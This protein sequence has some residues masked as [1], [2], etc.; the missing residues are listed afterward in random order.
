MIRFMIWQ[1]CMQYIFIVLP[2]TSFVLILL[3]LRFVYCSFYII[4]KINYWNISINLK[5]DFI[6][7]N[8]HLWFTV[9]GILWSLKTLLV[10]LDWTYCCWNWKYC[11]KIIFKCVNSTVGPIF[12]IF[13]IKWPWVPWTVSEQ[14]QNSAWT[15]TFVS[16]IINFVSFLKRV[17]AKK[18]KKKKKKKEKNTTQQTG[19]SSAIGFTRHK[20]WQNW[21]CVYWLS[22]IS[23]CQKCEL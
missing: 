6:Y 1:L 11:S 9:K 12:N 10:C 22:C 16:W 18:K 14:Y 4:T 19:T 13:L 21:V 7:F 2:I 3:I 17:K 5:A 23:L 20:F 8:L 15:V